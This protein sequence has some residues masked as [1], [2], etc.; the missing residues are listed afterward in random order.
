MR[1]KDKTF[2]KAIPYERI[3]EGVESLAERL[4]SDYGQLQGPAPLFVGV[5]NGAFMFMSELM[6]RLDFQCEATFVKV[7]SYSGTTSS[8]VVDEHIGLCC[9]V[10]GRNVVVVEDI[11]ETGRSLE[12]IM[13]M[14]AD[15]GAASVEVAAL[16][17]KPEVYGGEKTIKYHGMPI[18][19]DFIVGFGLDYDGLGRNLRDIYKVVE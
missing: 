3:I 11:V 19:N 16:F 9:D 17:F 12:H 7:S 5:L 13:R 14:L 8:G 1:L 4:N 15:G 18:P 10:R 2:E 6:Q